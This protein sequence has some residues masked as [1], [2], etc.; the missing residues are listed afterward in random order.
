MFRYTQGTLRQA[1]DALFVF[2]EQEMQQARQEATLSEL[3]QVIMQCRL[4]TQRKVQEYQREVLAAEREVSLAE[5][6]LSKSKEILN[7]LIYKK[8]KLIY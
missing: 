7:N 8:D 3:K 4:D 2:T 6:K 1:F 5:K